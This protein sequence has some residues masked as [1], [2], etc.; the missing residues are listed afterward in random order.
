M[1]FGVSI[2]FRHDP[3]AKDPC[4]ETY[5]LCQLA[6]EAGFDFL[7]MGHHVF[8]PDYPTSAPFAILSAI[9]AR[10]SRIE[11]AS[12]IYLL[13]LYHPVAVAEQVATLDLISGGRAIFGI[14]V[15]YRDYEYEGF[16]VDPRRRGAR[17]DEAMAAIRSAW[18]TGR[19]NFQGEHFLIPDL[20]AVPMPIRKPHPPMWVGGVSQPAIR[21][22]AR[23][24]DGWITANMQPMDEVVALADSYRD[25]CAA[26]G[27]EPFLCISRDAWVARTRDEMMRDWYPD[28]V[29]RHI[30]FKRMGFTKAD[31][32]GVLDRLEAGESVPPEEFID[33]RVIGGTPAD[34]IGQ[35]GRWRESA[36]CQSMLMLLSKKASF[37][38][39]CAVIRRFGDEVLPA[40]RADLSR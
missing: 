29:A 11:L 20:P 35:I 30:G 23:L 4:H 39:L 40:F 28:M 14:G 13:P 12:V 21:R 17:T 31:P 10:T 32:K 38:Q 25:A 36:Q 6:E 27:R 15:G 8:T 22:A 16:G 18:T 2:P 34:C 7:S 24:G 9:A 37:E 3:H 19:F 1:K 26:E 33:D 5:R